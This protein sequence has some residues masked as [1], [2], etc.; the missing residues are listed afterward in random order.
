[1]SKG[2]IPTFHTVLKTPIKG[3]RMNSPLQSITD[4]LKLRI[5]FKLPSSVFLRF[6][7]SLSKNIKC[8]KY[9]IKLQHREP[10]KS[11]IIENSVAP[12]T[13]TQIIVDMDISQ[14]HI[15]D[16]LIDDNIC[17]DC[18]LNI[19]L[20]EKPIIV[21]NRII[22]HS[23]QSIN[24]KEMEKKSNKYCGLM[25]QGGTCYLN[26]YLQILFHLPAFRRIVYSMGVSGTED[27]TKSIPINLQNLF[28]DLQ[29]CDDVCYTF[30]LT[31]SFGW[32]SKT[33]LKQQDIHEF[34]L[35]LLQNL[36]KKLKGTALENSIDDLFMGEEKAYIRCINC[37]FKTT[38]VTKFLSLSLE[39][40][41]CKTLEESFENYM[42]PSEVDDYQTDDEKLGKQKATYGIESFIFPKVLFIH[43]K[44]FNYDQK[45]MMILK[46]NSRL[47]FPE[48]LD[49]TKF[50]AKSEKE[51]LY[52]LIGVM[53]HSG[54]VSGGHYYSFIKKDQGQWYK[55]NDSRVTKEGS[56]NAV[57]AN[58]GSEGENS[59]GSSAYY[60]VY[61]RK[62]DK[63]E[64]FK[65]IPKDEIPQ[66]IIESACKFREE[67]KKEREMREQ[68]T[69]FHI[70]TR[71]EDMFAKRCKSIEFGFAQTLGDVY[72][73]LDISK[74]STVD[75]LYKQIAAQYEREDD[76][77]RL[78]HCEKLM[79]PVSQLNRSNEQIVSLFSP[80]TTNVNLFVQ[81]KPKQ[82][83]CN[84]KDNQKVVY[85]KFF[86]NAKQEISYVSSYLVD[87]EESF[88][89]IGKRVAA[90]K[91]LEESTKLLSFI[92]KGDNSFT[93]VEETDKVK[94]HILR[95]GAII[96]FQCHPEDEKDTA[97]SLRDT[98]MSLCKTRSVFDSIPELRDGLL[99][100][101]IA[102]RKQNHYAVFS[103]DKVD[104]QMCSIRAPLSITYDN[105]KLAISRESGVAFDPEK[106][107]M[108]LFP[109]DTIGNCGPKPQHFDARRSPS[110]D[111]DNLTTLYA[112]IIDGISDKEAN[113][114]SLYSVQYSSDAV[115]VVFSD[116]VLA[117]KNVTPCELLNE[118]R[119]KG[120]DVA[121][122]KHR[123]FFMS[124]GVFGNS[125]SMDQNIQNN[126]VSIRI[127]KIPEEQQDQ[128][129][130]K[131]IPVS[132]C[133]VDIYAKTKYFG[134]PFIFT[135][136]NDTFAVV[137][138]K[139]MSM[140]NKEIVKNPRFEIKDPSLKPSDDEIIFD[141][142]LPNTVINVVC[143]ESEYAE[144]ERN[145]QMKNIQK[146][147]FAAK[148]ETKARSQG[149]E[150]FN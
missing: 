53:V 25:N 118:I 60:L 140:L 68:I 119:K 37:N 58:F 64:V 85:C 62:C 116:T 134:D 16:Y 76:S 87:D 146:D 72:K 97:I 34:S 90:A 7:E 31:R 132:T 49:L 52:E 70:K 40:K 103:Y 91:G 57:N 115:H 22:R 120:V 18:T 28:C 99:P 108:L 32:D 4:S 126:I 127:E 35:V 55:F 92:E 46:L 19:S 56:K 9:A 142:V 21:I 13:K 12:L 112:K 133:F 43:L 88:E 130:V 139:I 8:C 106:Q 17:I 24:V 141:K 96:I 95:N 110:V 86:S 80:S 89:N 100:S 129:G 94:D 71:T 82:E 145:K 137:K 107:A 23:P 69:S 138:E 10:E 11:I 144:S 102:E 48:E 111:F 59:S 104:E 109:G 149:V 5:G 125:L 33:V 65:E 98:K 131:L 29:V 42:N 39:V 15:N 66:H 41:G 148:P 150:I 3:T 77:I 121:E 1:M 75:D 83:E 117:K 136:K 27:A 128:Q 50:S 84:I 2:E 30:N 26:S 74:T 101:F 113:D 45:N 51:P 54:D 81:F 20:S 67:A 73:E 122:G 124:T 123:A 105:L 14:D 78:W 114:L 36:I 47:E 6:S 44:R 93:K 135:L 79:V 143:N 38:K 63:E 147:H 61:V